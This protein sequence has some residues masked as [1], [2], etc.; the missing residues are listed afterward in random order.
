MMV[1][2]KDVTVPTKNQF[3][4]YHAYGDQSLM[5][6]NGDHFGTIVYTFATEQ[7][8]ILNFLHSNLK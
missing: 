2:L 6:H 5:T 7:L 8:R 1:A 3:A 4:L